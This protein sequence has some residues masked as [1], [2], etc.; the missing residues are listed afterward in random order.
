MYTAIDNEFCKF[1]GYLCEQRKS[2]VCTLDWGPLLRFLIA[3]D[4]LSFGKHLSSCSWNRNPCGKKPSGYSY[5]CIRCM[6]KTKR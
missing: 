6:K 3:G 2:D 4:L 1:A 5:G